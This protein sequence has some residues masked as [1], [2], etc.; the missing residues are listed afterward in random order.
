MA[1]KNKKEQSD[2]RMQRWQRIQQKN[3][4]EKQNEAQ[5]VSWLYRFC[6]K[7]ILYKQKG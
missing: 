3:K 2:K 7:T 1:K 6:K 4:R 5:L